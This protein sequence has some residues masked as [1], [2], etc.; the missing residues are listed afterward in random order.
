MPRNPEVEYIGNRASWV[1]ARPVSVITHHNGNKKERG[2]ILKAYG[3][4][5]IRS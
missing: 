3:I 1:F 4:A 2:V 5:A